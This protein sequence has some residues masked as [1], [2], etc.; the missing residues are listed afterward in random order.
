[1]TDEATGAAR[2]GETHS[3]DPALE[4]LRETT[5]EQR[6]V[7]RGG[8]MTFRRDT[9]RDVDGRV[10]TRDIVDHPGAVA[11]VA[12]D[13]DDQLLL[14]RQ[15]RA[16]IGRPLLEIPAGTLDR[17]EDGGI[18]SPDLAAP[19]E[20]GEETGVV[21]GSWRKLGHFWTAPGFATEDMHLYVATH[22]RPLEGYAGPEA[23][24]RLDVERVP[25]DEAV[26]MC[27]DGRINDAKTIGGVLWTDRLRRDGSL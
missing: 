26:G 21:A 27:I 13:D 1:M 4:R 14:V 17:L 25:W 23:D 7:H 16:A 12:I 2:P 10:H 22:L 24:E 3:E 5:I 18:E 15:W 11:I 6:V 9:V 20:L 19:R 8:Y